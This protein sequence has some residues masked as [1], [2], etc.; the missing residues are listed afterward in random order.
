MEKVWRKEIL[1]AWAVDDLPLDQQVI[2]IFEQV[3]D[4][5][6]GRMGSRDPW[7]VCLVLYLIN[8]HSD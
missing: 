2:K 1:K 8:P 6:F 5:P 4:I 7:D 3:W